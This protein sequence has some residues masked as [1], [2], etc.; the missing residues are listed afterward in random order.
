MRIL[1]KSRWDNIR[2]E[3]SY[4]NVIAFY[5]VVALKVYKRAIRLSKN[6]DSTTKP[7]HQRAPPRI[8]VEIRSLEQQTL[9]NNTPVHWRLEALG[10]WNRPRA[11]WP[12]N[13]GNLDRRKLRGCIHS[14]HLPQGDPPCHGRAAAWES[15]SVNRHSPVTTTYVRCGPVAVQDHPW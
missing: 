6:N 13:G 12:Q 1:R 11:W 9:T 4:R 7:Y 15:N 8:S 14:F 5:I 10:V 3:I 2:K